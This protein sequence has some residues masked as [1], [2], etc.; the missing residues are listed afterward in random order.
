MEDDKYWSE[1]YY[2][3]QFSYFTSPASI[4][5][6][7]NLLNDY[8]S[9][10]LN[11]AVFCCVLF[12]TIGVPGNLLT[13]CAL[14]KAKKLHNATTAFI[15]NL[16]IADL[17]FCG[18]N[19]PLI[20]STFLHR[21]WVH[22]ELLCQLSPFFRYSN[23]AVSLFTV[24][25]ITINRYVMIA[26]Q[27][28][29]PRFYQFR[30][31]TAMI[32]AIWIFSFGTLVP[33]LLGVWGRFGFDPKVGTC[34]ILPVN[35]QS[36]KAFL[37]IVAFGLPCVVITICYLRIF[38]IVKRTQKAA[39]KLQRLRTRITP[40]HSGTLQI[41]AHNEKREARDLRLIKMILVIFFS[42]VACY[43]PVTL[44]KVFGKE[45]TLPVTNICGYILIF[46][47][48]CINPI[49]YVLMSTEYRKAYRNLFMCQSYREQ[50]RLAQPPSS[51]SHTS[52]L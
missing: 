18:F 2:Y 43:L 3:Y 29:Y 10:L 22:G 1:D 12:I 11:F 21:G 31:L 49:I 35:N 42:F 37:F 5:H 7:A 14:T 28:L 17:L 6:E 40:G 48:A 52:K 39:R 30:S 36:P 23:V 38:W 45:E 16:S 27:Q 46:M 51:G 8:P 26:H 19:L 34:S 20:V 33:T 25:A 4:L 50:T 32:A 15:I 9:A 13:I 47:S 24:L 44:V 41:D